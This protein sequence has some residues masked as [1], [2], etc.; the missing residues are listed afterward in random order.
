MTVRSLSLLAA[1]AILVSGVGVRAAGAAHPVSAHLVR[2]HYGK[3]NPTSLTT[4]GDRVF[5]VLG[6]EFTGCGPGGHRAVRV[7]SS[8]CGVTGTPLYAA[9][10]SRGKL[11]YHFSERQFVSSLVPFR[12]GVVLLAGSTIWKS[13]GTR[14]GS[15]PLASL[16]PRRFGSPVYPHPIVPAGKRAFIV[17]SHQI[18]ITDGTRAGTR[19]VVTLPEINTGYGSGRSAAVLNGVL[20][21]AARDGKHGIELWKSDGTAAGTVIV[22][23]LVKGPKGSYPG[24]FTAASRR[25]YFIT[26]Y[27]RGGWRTG[28]KLYV[29]QGSAATTHLLHSFKGTKREPL[30][31]SQTAPHNF[32]PSGDGAFFSSGDN[33]RHSE[34]WHSDG[35][36]KGTGLLKD[37]YPG[38]SSHPGDFTALGAQVYFVAR[39]GADRW[40]L[41]KTDGTRAGTR[42][43]LDKG[44][45]DLISGGGRVYFM[46]A[47][48]NRPAIWSSDGTAV[49]TLP[50][51]TF[52]HPLGDGID[53]NLTLAGKSLYFIATLSGTKY[54]L[55]S[56]RLP[57]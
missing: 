4:A 3:S 1:L 43:F 41:W 45:S 17:G 57:Y 26:G 30:E 27:R 38:H 31:E 35:T 56:V 46:A 44:V 55:W 40:E 9:K 29:T 32:F 48:T 15:I 51:I 14:A 47:N 20:Y 7:A 2:V 5:F 12:K 6:E 52:R 42:V 8:R 13:D 25:I 28:W 23:D 50:I 54:R 11:V 16:P 19:L 18:W 21:F 49:G 37:I 33:P 22:K 34:L 10:S 24:V 36:R 39:S 53:P